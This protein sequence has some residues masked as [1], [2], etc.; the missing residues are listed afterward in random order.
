MR[1]DIVQ[2]ALVG[3]SGVVVY[4]PYGI[5]YH[6]LTQLH[7]GVEAHDECD[8]IA[9]VCYPSAAGLDAE[10]VTS[11]AGD[12]EEAIWAELERRYAETWG[13]SRP[14]AALPVRKT[15]RPGTRVR[16]LN[17]AAYTLAYCVVAQ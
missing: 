13:E 1:I 8:W 10:T 16:V 15:I 5:E 6:S 2:W 12:D 3:P 11:V 7:N 17:G 14:G 4:T 9:G